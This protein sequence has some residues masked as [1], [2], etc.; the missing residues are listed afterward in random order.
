MIH[1][2]EAMKMWSEEI[3]HK[4]DEI[5]VEKGL[6]QDSLRLERNYSKD[7]KL[8]TSYSIAVSSIFPLQF[9]IRCIINLSPYK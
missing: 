7:G 2:K 1:K 5:V 4:L 9:S 3:Q 8:I 6:P